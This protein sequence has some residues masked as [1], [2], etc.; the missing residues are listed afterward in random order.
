MLLKPKPCSFLSFLL[1]ANNNSSFIYLEE[2][3]GFD[4]FLYLNEKKVF[5]IFFGLFLLHLYLYKNESILKEF[6][7]NIIVVSFNRVCFE[8]YALIEIIIYFMYS[9]FGLNY[10]ITSYNVF[11]SSFGI[12]FFLYLLS[13]IYLV[14][15]NLPIRMLTK[16]FLSKES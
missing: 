5:A 4:K 2:L 3:N 16:K 8:F 11:F 15:F 6:G 7:S 1:H 13:S 9:I 10:Q 12:I 14:L